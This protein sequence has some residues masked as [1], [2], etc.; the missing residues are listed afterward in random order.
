MHRNLNLAVWSSLAA[1][2]GATATL[3][4]CSSDDQRAPSSR[5]ETCNHP[6]CAPTDASTAKDTAPA[7]EAGYD[8]PVTTVK[9]VLW[10]LPPPNFSPYAADHP[11]LQFPATIR[12]Y[13]VNHDYTATYDPD[14]GFE[15]SNVPIGY[16]GI[17]AEDIDGLNGLYST[18]WPLELPFAGDTMWLAVIKRPDIDAVLASVTPPLTVNLEKASLLVTVVAAGSTSGAAEIVIAPPKTAEAVLYY[19]EG[20]W[21]RDLAT[22]T[23]GDGQALIVNM[24]ANPY[25]GDMMVINY[26]KVGVGKGKTEKAVPVAQGAITFV[27]Q[28]ESWSAP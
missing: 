17:L 11:L 24:D 6:G 23:G 12:A 26:S 22:G 16:Y 27:Y 21:Q 28:T 4:A 19:V 25:P 10:W 3:L 7:G 20:K 5:W 15:L 18:Y 8:G 14:A 2:V 9:G 1:L 13:Y